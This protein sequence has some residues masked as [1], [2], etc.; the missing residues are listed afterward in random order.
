MRTARQHVVRS[1]QPWRLTCI[2]SRFTFLCPFHS[3]ENLGGCGGVETPHFRFVAALDSWG[4][5]LRLKL[6]YLSPPEK[7]K[8]GNKV[9][10]ASLREWSIFEIPFKFAFQTRHCSRSWFAA[11]WNS[12]AVAMYLV[13]VLVLFVY[14]LILRNLQ[15][16]KGFVSVKQNRFQQVRNS[17]R[18]CCLNQNRTPAGYLTPRIRMRSWSLG[19]G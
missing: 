1:T 13:I 19:G 17:L 12:H 11:G 5:W 18:K 4:Y 14:D 10:L 16:T 7:T 15:R 8:N 3:F 2:R 9:V 6:K